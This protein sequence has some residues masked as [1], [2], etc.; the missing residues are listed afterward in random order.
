MFG[1]LGLTRTGGG[2]EA[3]ATAAASGV[4]HA[5][6]SN[7]APPK[8]TIPSEE[9]RPTRAGLRRDEGDVHVH[10]GTEDARAE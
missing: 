9:H 6:S 4:V 8:V 5:T 10:A 2:P 1:S 3:R 7:H